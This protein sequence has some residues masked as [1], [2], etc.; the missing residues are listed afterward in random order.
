MTYGLSRMK[1]HIV[2]LILLAPALVTIVAVIGYPIV[3]AIWLTLQDYNVLRPDRTTFAGFENYLDTFRDP[4][5]WQAL[6]NS[7]VWVGGAVSLQI[8]FGF[9]GALL[10]NQRFVG[11]YLIRG[12]VLIPWATPS[13]LVA[14]MWMWMLDG[15]YGVLNDILRNLGVID[16]YVPWFAQPGTALPTLILIDVWQGVP[17]FAVMLLAALQAFPKELEDAAVVD[18]ANAWQ[19]LRFIKI[20]FIMPTLLITTVLRI[21]WTANYMDLMFIITNGGPGFR[22]TTLPFLAYTTSYRRLDFGQ[23]ATVAFLQALLLAVVIVVYIR[24]LRRREVI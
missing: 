19:Q 6:R 11:R 22:T 15:N 18:G 9:L 10:L 1:R 7:L 13:V 12:I 16:R 20:P 5:F 4:V 8:L 14:L 23:G 2:P 3:R 21:I 17:F 24:L